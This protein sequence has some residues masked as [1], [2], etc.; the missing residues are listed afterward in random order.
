MIDFIF[1][2]WSRRAAGSGGFKGWGGIGGGFWL[3]SSCLLIARNTLLDKGIASGGS[4]FGF[5]FANLGQ[6]FFLDSEFKTTM[7][8]FSLRLITE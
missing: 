5:G 4:R 6:S 1:L 3:V 8:A 2:L 7:F